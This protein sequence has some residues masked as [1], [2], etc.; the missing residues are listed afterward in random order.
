MSV[1]DNVTIMEQKTCTGCGQTKPID[2]FPW[3]KRDIRRNPRCRVCVY[4]QNAAW[5]KT[6]KGQAFLVRN[7]PKNRRSCHLKK[8]YG[9]TT[10]EFTAHVARC[11]NCC[12][13]CGVEGWPGGRWPG[14][15]S[16][17]HNRATGAVRGLLCMSCNVTLGHVHDD[18][19]Q[20][21]SLITY[22]EKHNGRS[23]ELPS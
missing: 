9:M 12:E 10:A 5:R 23:A 14:T 6:A 21:Q 19:G 11:N 4:A 1:Q 15:P 22:L 13:V 7:R 3:Y 16:V 8:A 18:I 20:L 2:A 17:D